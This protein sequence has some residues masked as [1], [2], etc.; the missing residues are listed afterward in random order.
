MFGLSRQT[1]KMIEGEV[2]RTTHKPSP[3]EHLEAERDRVQ[4]EIQHHTRIV[5]E[6]AA[7]I[8]R[9]QLDAKAIQ[10]ALDTY[11]S[12]EVSAA[13]LEYELSTS[14]PARIDDEIPY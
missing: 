13:E 2:A 9:L 14:F 10:A 11:A 5:D 1:T 7:N 6:A 4:M 12:T 8:A 3:K